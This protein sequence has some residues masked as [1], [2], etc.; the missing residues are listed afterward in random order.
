MNTP[1][2]QDYYRIV[3]ELQQRGVNG[4]GGAIGTGVGGIIP[5]NYTMKPVENICAQTDQ[6]SPVKKAMVELEEEIEVCAK[7]ISALEERLSY[8]LSESHPEPPV[9]TEEPYMSGLHSA[10]TQKM[11]NVRTIR[12]N[13]QSILSRLTL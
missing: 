6:L 4:I 3:A 13:A 10:I 2:Q 12:Q 1:K 9:S 7:V 8:I 11:V 5:P